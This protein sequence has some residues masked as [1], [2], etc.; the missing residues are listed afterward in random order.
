MITNVSENYSGGAYTFSLSCDD[1]LVWWR[2]QKVTLNPSVSD[3]YFGG[4]VNNRFPT[5]FE[6]MSS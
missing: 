1:F 6:R 4:A 5:V 2:F 3:Y